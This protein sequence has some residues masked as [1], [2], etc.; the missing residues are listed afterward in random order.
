MTCILSMNP[1]AGQSGQ[2]TLTVTAVDA[3][4]QSS[5]GTLAL[6]VTPA[7]IG[8]GGGALDCWSLLILGMWF[9]GSRGAACGA[10]RRL[11]KDLSPARTARR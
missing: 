11:A 1:I 3:Y 10:T 8:G 5:H 6:N 2:A 9:A 4:G 7:P